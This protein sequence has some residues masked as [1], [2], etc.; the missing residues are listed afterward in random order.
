MAATTTVAIAALAWPATY[1]WQAFYIDCHDVSDCHIE[2][3]IRSF[4]VNQRPAPQTYLNSHPPL[5]TRNRSVSF[6]FSSNGGPNTFFQCRLGAVS[7][8]SCS[9]PKS[10]YLARG[11]SYTFQVRAF[12]NTL[13][14][15]ILADPT[16]AS[17]SFRIRR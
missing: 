2:S 14:G 6:T 8:S 16:P 3:A 7:W 13:A 11:H 4:H 1:Y 12:Q 9:S 15:P 5:S 17:W 10:Y